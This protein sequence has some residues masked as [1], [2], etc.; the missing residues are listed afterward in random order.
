ME[1]S[2]TDKGVNLLAKI[3]AGN[4]CFHLSKALSGSGYSI[5]PQSLSDVQ[6]VKQEIQIIKVLSNE[7]ITMVS[8]LLSNTEILESYNLRQLGLFAIDDETQEEI[9]FII[10]Q[11]FNGDKVPAATDGIVEYTYN[12]SLK[13]SNTA[14][15]VI[16]ANVGDWIIEKADAVLEKTFYE[17]F[18]KMIGSVD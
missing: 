14:D 3:N 11:D 7:G 13:V 1:Y 8:L 6:E 4:S 17:V 10:G 2:L 12:V 15:V 5:L 18:T 16:E 9:L